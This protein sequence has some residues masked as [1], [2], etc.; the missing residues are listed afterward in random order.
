MVGNIYTKFYILLTLTVVVAT[1]S[2]NKMKM[3]VVN[4]YSLWELSVTMEFKSDLT[5]SIMQPFTLPNN[6]SD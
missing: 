6:A 3:L 1:L 2:V 4:V 5:Q